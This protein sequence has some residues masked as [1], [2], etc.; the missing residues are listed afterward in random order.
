MI[1]HL[2]TLDRPLKILGIGSLSYV[3]GPLRLTAVASASFSLVG[4]SDMDNGYFL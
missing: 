1:C 2:D 4:G 3:N